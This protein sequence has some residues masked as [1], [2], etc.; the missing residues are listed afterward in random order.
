MQQE[1]FGLA[2]VGFCSNPSTRIPWK[3]HRAARFVTVPGSFL[4]LV[5]EG[6]QILE[7]QQGV[8]IIPAPHSHTA[9]WSHSTSISHTQPAEAGAHRGTTHTT[10]LG[11]FQRQTHT[12]SYSILLTYQRW[13]WMLHPK[14]CLLVKCIMGVNWPCVNPLQNAIDKLSILS[15][16]HS[17]T[18]PPEQITHWTHSI[19]SDLIQLFFC[20]HMN[21]TFYIII[22]CVC[23]CYHM[24]WLSGWTPFQNLCYSQVLLNIYKCNQEFEIQWTEGDPP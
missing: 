22:L 12:Y 17:F 16:W 20:R 9:G 8:R 5:I 18:P 15:W 4:W 1:G 21:N 19:I 24:D 7:L 11:D 10:C 3:D 23:V 2:G 6:K 14:L 13:T